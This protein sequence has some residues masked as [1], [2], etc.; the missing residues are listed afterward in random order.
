M[1]VSSEMVSAVHE[2][3]MHL[4]F[5]FWK[6]FVGKKLMEPLSQ[7]GAVP[8]KVISKIKINVEMTAIIGY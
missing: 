1:I 5:Q 7:E 8:E 2:L 3:N 6:S 4:F